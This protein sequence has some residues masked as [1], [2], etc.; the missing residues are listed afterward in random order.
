MNYKRIS[1]NRGNMAMGNIGFEFWGVNSQGEF[2]NLP[3]TE[4]LLPFDNY[5]MILGK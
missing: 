4:A 1:A 5:E 3:F 2:Q